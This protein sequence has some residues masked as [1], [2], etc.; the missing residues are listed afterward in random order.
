MED[1]GGNQGEDDESFDAM[2]Q[3]LDGAK[4][5]Y[6]E[7]QQQSRRRKMSS[8]T[9]LQDAMRSRT[10]GAVLASNHEARLKEIE[11][12]DAV[13]HRS[14]KA[15]TTAKIGVDAHERLP[16]YYRQDGLVTHTAYITD[17]IVNPNK[18][19]A[20]AKRFVEHVTDDDTYDQYHEQLDTT[21]FIVSGGKRL[22]EPFPQSELELLSGSGNVSADFSRQ[23]AYVVQRLGDFET[24]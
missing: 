22:D 11:E 21:T 9:P 5:R 18:N 4:E 14:G 3:H 6:K 23:P 16:I 7:N 17:I 15:W 1:N 20:R 10:D 13:T 19:T 12:N 8:L 24:T 2:F